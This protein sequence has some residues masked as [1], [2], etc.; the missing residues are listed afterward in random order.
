MRISLPDWCLLI[1]Q[2][3]ITHGSFPRIIYPV[4]FSEKVLC[5]VLFDRRPLLTQITDKASVRF[6]VESRLGRQILPQ[7]Y[8]LT[9]NPDTIPFDELPDKFVVKPTHASGWV[10]FVTDKS[11]LDRTS[12]L[13]TCHDWLK[14]SYYK[15]SHERI[16]K[17][18]KPRIIVEE[19]I[20]DHGAEAP[21]D[22]KMFVFGGTVELIQIDVGRFSHHRERLYTPAWEKIDAHFDLEDIA[23]DMPPPV[24]LQGM[25]A[26]AE[27]L[28]K[29]WDFIRVDFYD[30]GERIYFGELTVAPG[31]GCVRIHPKEFNRYLGSLWKT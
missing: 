23:G 8:H 6:Y 10:R 25:I 7:L 27:T 20:D 13:K 15:E 1:R 28:G 21:T 24:H 17:L 31:R 19:F 9:D 11:T 12:L 26:A 4:T 5:R 18:I 30:T 29:D 14:R 22:Y 16:Y 3:Y 2:W